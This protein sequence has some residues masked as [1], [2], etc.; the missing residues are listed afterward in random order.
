MLKLFFH[1]KGF[2]W[3]ETL[4]ISKNQNGISYKKYNKISINHHRLCKI[5]IFFF[6]DVNKFIKQ[7]YSFIIGSCQC[8]NLRELV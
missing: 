7:L 1:L 4:N 8:F 2:I 6:K 3:V 5:L